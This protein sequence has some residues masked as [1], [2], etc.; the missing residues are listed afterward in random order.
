M[1]LWGKKGYC[2]AC[3]VNISIGLKKDFH[4]NQHPVIAQYDV[5][6]DTLAES[7]DPILAGEAF[8][9]AGK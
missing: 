9:Q 4:P 1:V 8:W 6:I 2:P 5:W 7:H 3:V